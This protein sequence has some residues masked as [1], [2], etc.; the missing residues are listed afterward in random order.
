MTSSA[1]LPD[2]QPSAVAG[3]DRLRAAA[4]AGVSAGLRTP[5]AVPDSNS[6]LGKVQ[7]ILEAFGP[8]DETL[9][10]S[11]LSRRTGLAKASVHRLAQELVHW[12]L[13]ERGRGDY[14]L[15]MRLFEIG[16]RVPRQ[17]ILREV[18]RPFM[19]DLFQATNETVHL[20]VLDGLDVLYLEKVSGH[21][22]V[23][24]PSRVAGRMP[25]HCTATGK[26]LVAFGPTALFDEVVSAPLQRVTPRTVV[27]PKLLAQDLQRARES[28]YAVEY[29]QTR[30]GYMSVAIPLA[31]STGVT[32]AALSVTAP[33]ARGNV[34]RYAGLLNMV[35]RRVT[36]LLSVRDV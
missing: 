3:R 28:G 25:L 11:E 12:G 23:S 2:V 31:G 16:Q 9:S 6:V 8:D 29:E 21:S 4:A 20:A 27:S 30:I 26:A 18:A 32:V 19:E 35:S 7:R 17:R 33:T 14:R 22:Q 15:G 1:K 10:L 13:M 36:K 34:E 5:E 24:R